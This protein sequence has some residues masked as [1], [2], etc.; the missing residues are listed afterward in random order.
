MGGNALTEC[1]VFGR[2]AGNNAARYALTHGPPPVV[3]KDLPEDLVPHPSPGKTPYRELRHIIRDISW[4]YAGVVRLEEGLKTG[5]SKLEELNRELKET[6]PKSVREI[7]IKEDLMSAVFVLKAVL[8]ASLARRESRGCFNRKDFP[9]E[10]NINWR[11]N[12]SLFYE[13]E[14]ESFSVSHHQVIES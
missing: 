5:M 12:S 9:Q 14:E 4:K 8:T 1:V 13:P 2:I 10:D 11:K 6:L 7:K 3:S